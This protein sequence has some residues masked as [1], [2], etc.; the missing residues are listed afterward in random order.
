MAVVRA[1]HILASYYLPL[2]NKEL[3]KLESWGYEI[4]SVIPVTSF[5]GYV[6]FY[7]ILVYRDDSY[8]AQQKS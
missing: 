5:L 6:N 3:A 7:T 8:S 4:K 2:L 1:S